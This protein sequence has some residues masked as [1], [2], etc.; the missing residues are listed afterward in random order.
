MPKDKVLG[1][2]KWSDEEWTGT[3]SLPYFRGAGERVA[4]TEDD[5][6]GVPPA[7]AIPLTVQTGGRRR[8]PDGA[9]RAAWQSIAGRGDAVWDEAMDVLVAEYQGQRPNRVRYWKV[10]ND[11]KL[12]ARSM[13]EQVDRATMRQMVLPLQCTIN[14]PDKEHKTVDVYVT[15]LATWWSEA[16]CVY[17]RDGRVTEVSPLGFFMNR[18]LPWTDMAALGTL[19]RRPGK[20][21]QWV[22]E[23]R[24]EPFEGFAAVA[25][26]RSTWDESYQ[27]SDP[28]T[29]DLPWDPARGWGTLFVSAPA[30]KPPTERQSAA[31]EAFVKR[32]DEY[33]A[34]I[35]QAVFDHYRQTATQRRK[36]Y[37]GPDP[38]AAVPELKD[39]KGLRDVTEL[40]EIDVFPDEGSGPVTL[41]FVFRGSWTGTD[42]I[43]LLWRDGKV[44]QI[45]DA[46]IAVPPLPPA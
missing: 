26:D 18:R 27:R 2:I 29:S 36:A 3:V 6:M 8:E 17:A 31:Y 5:R 38:N 10:V 43:G 13:P 7:E 15:M 12:L 28:A 4:L 24:L 22:G 19:R 30:G 35:L 21:S 9:Q 11:P 16:L 46:K 34:G 14:E 37:R 41:G 33:A 20:R 32:Q 23:V 42:G 39:A 1:N 25:V 44:E 40:K 45:G